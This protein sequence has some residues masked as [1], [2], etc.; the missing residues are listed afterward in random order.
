MTATKMRARLALALLLVAV[1]P[2]PARSQLPPA[3]EFTEPFSYS[4]S[5]TTTPAQVVG[6]NPVRRR[7]VFCNPSLTALVAV[8]PPITRGGNIIA[9]AVNGAGGVTL[10]PYACQAFEGTVNNPLLPT[11]WNAVANSGAAALTVWEWE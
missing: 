1:L 6:P 8:C 5:L 2:A 4:A 10:L 7:I 9:C 3:P 11:S